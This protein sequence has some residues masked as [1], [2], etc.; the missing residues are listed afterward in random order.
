MFVA[1]VLVCL[2]ALAAPSVLAVVC[3]QL[4]LWWRQLCSHRGVDVFV[5]LL[6]GRGVA[7]RVVPMPC[8]MAAGSRVL[9]RMTERGSR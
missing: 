9:G 5:P 7:R 3:F 6:P 1:V 4:L 2:G 8:A